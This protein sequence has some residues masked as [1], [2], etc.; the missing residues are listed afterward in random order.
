MGTTDVDRLRLD[1]MESISATLRTLTA[2]QWDAPSLCEGWRTRDVISHMLVGYTV[3]MDQI[4]AVIERYH[5]DI[6]AASREASI[7]YGSAHTPEELA[8]GYERLWRGRVF[9][10]GAPVSPPG[11]APGGPTPHPPATCPPLGVAAR[12]GGH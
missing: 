4:G 7:E 3:P 1:E 9:C 6:A 2:E 5:G 11:G 8:D 10:G 12:A